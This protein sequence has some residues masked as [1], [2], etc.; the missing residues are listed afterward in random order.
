MLSLIIM[1]QSEMTVISSMR[2][3]TRLFIHL[4]FH[5]GIGNA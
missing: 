1:M 5:M 4:I 2:L 3:S